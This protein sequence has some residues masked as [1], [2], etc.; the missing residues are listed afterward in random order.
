MRNRSVSAGLFVR[1]RRASKGCPRT[2]SRAL[3]APRAGRTITN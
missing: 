1:P 2:R 3:G